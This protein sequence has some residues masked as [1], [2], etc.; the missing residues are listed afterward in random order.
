MQG[1]F[2]NMAR[3]T[4][5]GHLLLAGPLGE[6]R[7]EASHR[8]LFLLDTTD[9][10]EARALAQSD[11]AF[12]AGSFRFEVVP[13]RTDDPVGELPALDH[14]ARFARLADDPTQTPET[15]W[16]G[17]G[18]VILSGRADAAHEEAG[19]ALD[20]EGLVAFTLRLRRDGGEELWLLLDVQSADA[21]RERL[22]A[23]LEPWTLHGWYGSDVV[24][25]LA[26]R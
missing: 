6:P 7:G 14:G 17:R 1:H 4:E 9:P 21:A 16:R 19:A 2:T 12:R 13:A 24:A 26:G 23:A 22:G 25:D 5:E 3:L 20:A 11:P 10:A 18:F 15:A 8:G